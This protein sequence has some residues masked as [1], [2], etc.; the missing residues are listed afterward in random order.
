MAHSVYS[1]S[2]MGRT[3]EHHCPAWIRMSRPYPNTTNP[4]AEEGTAAH[5]LREFNLTTGFRPHDCIG[6]EFNNHVVDE[7]M[8]D[9]V[10]ID[11]NYV[12]RLTIE[13]GVKPLLEQRVVMSGLGRNDV[14]GT[15]DTVFVVPKKRIVHII[16]FKY[17]RGAVE[18]KDNWQLRAYGVATLDTFDLWNSVDEVH[19]TITQPRF[20]HRDGPIRTEVY[21]IQQVDEFADV[22]FRS[23]NLADDPTTVP[24]AGEWCRYCPARGACRARMQRTLNMVFRNDLL[25]DIT[26]EELE[27][28]KEEL[29]TITSNI[30]SIEDEMLRRAKGG[31]RYHNFKLVDSRPRA[32]L[33]DEGEFVK[34]ASKHVNI[35]RLYDKKL[36]SPTNL[37]SLVPGEVID[38]H[39]KKPEPTEILV[40][41][42]DKRI[43]KM[44]K[45]QVRKGTFGKVSK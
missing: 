10:A 9:G 2:S 34:D 30:E 4:A 45:G 14:F 35:E 31:H 3:V 36:K 26:A 12:N 24:N 39:F 5:E 19:V 27:M 1:M 15:A 7:E 32:T 37:K 43:A 20:G 11:V 44:P 17:G 41:M 6:M 22:F 13:Y 33:R 42:N 29:P 8:A 38:K 18:V 40:P 16:D 23:V 21:T 28:I 25:T